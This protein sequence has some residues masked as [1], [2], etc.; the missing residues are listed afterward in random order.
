MR[1]I[2]DDDIDDHPTLS[3]KTSSRYR[4]TFQHVPA[5]EIYKPRRILFSVRDPTTGE[6]KNT[7][8]IDIVNLVDGDV[9]HNLDIST[10]FQNGLF[11][12]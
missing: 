9:L 12:T 11:I 1:V 8:Q 4:Q 10:E 3:A 6:F 5:E 7:I 2:E